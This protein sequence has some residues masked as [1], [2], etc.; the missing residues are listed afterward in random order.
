[1]RD[2]S[3]LDESM[4]RGQALLEPVAGAKQKSPVG[5]GDLNVES[6][7]R[8]IATPTIGPGIV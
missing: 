1:M 5:A 3:E 4:R 2:I 7:I 8:L 6:I